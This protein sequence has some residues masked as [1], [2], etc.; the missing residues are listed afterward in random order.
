M[1][2]KTEKTEAVEAVAKAYENHDPFKYVPEDERPSLVDLNL[3]ARGLALE[4]RQDL[5][6]K[7][8][9]VARAVRVAFGRGPKEVKPVAPK[10]S[11]MS[12]ELKANAATAAK[13]RENATKASGK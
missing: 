1:T 5:D 7:H 6:Q 9:V 10:G 4:R 11:S 2:D 3:R 8:E 12:T 13:A